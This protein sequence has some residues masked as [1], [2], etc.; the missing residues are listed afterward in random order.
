VVVEQDSAEVDLFPQK[1]LPNLICINVSSL[2]LLAVG[3]Q[4]LMYLCQG[5]QILKKG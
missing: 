2:Q 4:L 1:L 5:D 3:H